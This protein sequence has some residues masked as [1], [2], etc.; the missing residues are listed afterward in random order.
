M[1]SNAILWAQRDAEME[2]LARTE[3][4]SAA[5]Q[6][7]PIILPLA[8]RNAAMSAKVDGLLRQAVAKDAAAGGSDAE[9]CLAEQ[10]AFAAHQQR[11]HN[12]PGFAVVV[13]DSGAT[14]VFMFCHLGHLLFSSLTK[15]PESVCFWCG[16]KLN[17]KSAALPSD[18]AR[19]VAWCPT[20]NEFFC[21]S[22][23][24]ELRSVVLE[25]VWAAESD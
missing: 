18:K 25:C 7:T 6:S 20:C 17:S 9:V 23:Q 10:P 12:S 8:L 15:P 24:A 16:W 13:G 5:F 3:S 14:T 2:H 21:S 1:N 11:T 19:E 4:V 22:C